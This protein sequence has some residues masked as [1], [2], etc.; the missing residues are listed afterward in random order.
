MNLPIGVRKSGE[1]LK[2]SVIT[3]KPQKTQSLAP[4][5]M[6][7]RVIAFPDQYVNGKFVAKK[8]K[9]LV[10][11]EITM[12]QSDKVDAVLAN[13]RQAFSLSSNAVPFLPSTHGIRA[14]MATKMFD[15]ALRIVNSSVH[16]HAPGRAVQVRGI[17]REQNPALPE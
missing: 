5:D 10:D 14:Q 8:V 3:P 4:K 16:A 15:Q 6:R 17:T 9:A 12:V 2:T 13:A 11:G 1:D 7:G